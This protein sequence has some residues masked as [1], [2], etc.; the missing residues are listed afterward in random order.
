M[1]RYP[2]Q[3]PAKGSYIKFVPKHDV[4]TSNRPIATWY[5]FEGYRP[6]A[7]LRIDLYCLD[8]VPTLQEVMDLFPTDWEDNGCCFYLYTFIRSINVH[9][10]HLSIRN[11][12]M[13]MS[14]NSHS[15][16]FYDYNKACFHKNSKFSALKCGGTPANGT[17]WL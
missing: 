12:I 4:I 15:A 9:K 1:D 6:D 2:Y 13:R 8:K 16:I 3:V 5:H 7:I 10:K 14:G 17:K 11:C